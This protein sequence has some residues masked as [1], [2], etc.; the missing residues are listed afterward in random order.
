MPRG[1]G[2]GSAGLGPMT[3]RARGYCAGYPSSGFAN[4]YG[5]GW[6]MGMG[7]NRRPGFRGSG[8]RLWSRGRRRGYPTY[9]Y[10]G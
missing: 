4:P 10:Y 2:T 6:G 5:R 1:D 9:G 3:G 8:R 7:R